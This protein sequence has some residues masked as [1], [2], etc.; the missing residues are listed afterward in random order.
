MEFFIDEIDCSSLLVVTFKMFL[1]LDDG[2]FVVEVRNTGVNI[3]YEEVNSFFDSWTAFG[4]L[5]LI[6]VELNSADDAPV[7][8]V[9]VSLR[10][11]MFDAVFR[12]PENGR[13]VSVLGVLIFEPNNEFELWYFILVEGKKE[14]VEYNE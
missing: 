14:V 3:S 11:D 7:L 10:D 6:V 1:C 4:W 9:V 2:I 12:N 8:R 13:F 5:D